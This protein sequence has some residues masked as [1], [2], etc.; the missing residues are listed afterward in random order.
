[1]HFAFPLA[2]LVY[3]YLI[4]RAIVWSVVLHT[5]QPSLPL[6]VVEHLAWVQQWQF[7]YD[8]HPGGVAWILGMLDRIGGGSSFLFSIPSPIFV[9]LA[10]AAVWQMARRVVDEKRALV[11]VLSL[12]GIWYFGVVAFEFNPNIL[13][14]TIW[15]YLILLAHQ[16][17]LPNKKPATTIHWMLFGFV[18]AL[19]LYAKYASAILLA[20]LFLWSITD[21]NIRP[22]YRQHGVYV[23]MAAFVLFT[24]PQVLAF[25]SVDFAPFRYALG[26]TT[27]ATSATYHFIYPAKF[28]LAQCGAVLLAVVLCR[29]AV[30]K[31]APTTITINNADR[32]F[33]L[34]MAYAPLLLTTCISALGGWRFQSH[35][36]TSM[37][38]FIPLAVMITI[39]SYELNLRRFVKS[40]MAV[41]ALSII[42]LIAINVGAPFFNERGKRIHYPGEQ[43]GA[44]VE[45]LWKKQNPGKPLKAVVGSY[46]LSSLIS[47][48]APSRPRAVLDGNWNLSY[49][50]SRKQ[51][52]ESG[53]AIVWM[54]NDNKRQ[55]I[56]MPDYAKEYKT[57]ATTITLNW[58]THAKIPPMVIGIKTIPP[59]K[60]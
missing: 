21:K 49:V 26:R 27:E 43:I 32:R 13:L 39:G 38:S 36:G 56:P 29:I 25:W 14:L 7:V 57:P 41:A 59:K 31:N 12:E 54:I 15:A 37:L 47:F 35:W 17:F 24:L 40:A 42:A 60:P 20:V 48:Y 8:K 11:A 2:R 22:H 33:I 23:A 55:N 5:T 9:S 30:R 10:M 34:V 1:M 44:A 58:Q 52:N 4:A 18:A 16:V 28:L 45:A 51:F 6:D 19:S 53:G 3:Y 50:I 46:H